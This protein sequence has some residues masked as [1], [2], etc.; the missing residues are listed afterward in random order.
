L[1][2]SSLFSKIFLI[3]MTI[4]IAVR[5]TRRLI[6]Q[7]SLLKDKVENFLLKSDRIKGKKTERRPD[8]ILKFGQR[9]DEDHGEERKD[10]SV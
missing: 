2:R 3:H 8:T 6:R 5:Q 1:F 9:E 4:T 10:Q 7:N